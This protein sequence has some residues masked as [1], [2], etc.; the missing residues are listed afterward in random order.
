VLLWNRFVVLA[1]AVPRKAGGASTNSAG[2]AGTSSGAD[3]AVGMAANNVEVVGGAGV[4]I[5]VF[6]AGGGA[7]NADVESS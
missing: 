7:N 2:V 4:N 3:W 6:V 1:S 5:V